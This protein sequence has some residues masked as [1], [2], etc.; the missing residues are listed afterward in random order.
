MPRRKRRDAWASITEVRAGEVY[1]I[2]FWASGPDGYKRRSRTIRGTRKEAERAR[3]E[4]MLEHSDD[5]PCPTVGEAWERWYLP[6]LRQAVDGGERAPQ[7]LAQYS[8]RWK[9][10]VGPRWANV[11]CDSVRPLDV[12]QWIS[13]LGYNQAIYS[14]QLL[15]GILD[16][17]VRYGTVPSNPMRE[18][19]VMPP[20]STVR[21][22]D[23]GV[24]SLAELGEV[25]CAVRGSWIEPAFVLAAF[26][27]LRVGESMGVMGSDV[28]RREVGAQTVALVH[29]DRQVANNG[30]VTDTLKNAQSRRVVAIPGRAGAYLLRLAESERGYLTGDGM[31]GYSTQWRMK[32]EWDGHVLPSL[33]ETMRHPFTNLRNS[34]QTNM[35]W[36]LR[37]PPWLIEPMMGH[38]GEGVTGRHY[39]RPQAEMFAEVVAEAYAAHPFDAGWDDLGRR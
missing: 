27:G 11:P 18:R 34:W 28:E 19:Y 23:D 9:R 37:L 15:R 35:R 16:Y 7:T 32:K 2:R 39:D 6:T 25:W 21:R 12:Q 5:A 13:G 38:V 4:L 20:K 31:G 10:H 3:A 1:R 24:W 17:A 36:S 33:P 30:T 29:V 22:R 8:A 14:C 26:G